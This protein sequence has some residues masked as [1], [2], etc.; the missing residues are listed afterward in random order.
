MLYYFHRSSA[1]GQQ[2]QQSHMRAV[3]VVPSLL[4]LDQL[5]KATTAP[6]LPKVLI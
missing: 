4:L 5:Q 3:P 6:S 2:I 1:G